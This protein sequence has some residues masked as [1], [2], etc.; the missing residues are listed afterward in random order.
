MAYSDPRTWVTGE[1]V[2][3]SLMN[4]QLRDNLDAIVEGTT[5]AY[6]NAVTGPHAIGG[7]TVDYVRLGLTGAFTSGGASTLAFG[8]YTSGVLT[9]HS[10][11]SAAIAGIK[12]NNSIVTAGN[13]TTIAQL[14]VSEPQI[15]V[16]SGSVTNSAT[17]YIESAATEATNDYALWVDA[18]ATKLD[19]TLTVVG[20]VTVNTSD[21]FIDTSENAVVIGHTAIDGQGRALEVLGTTSDSTGIELMRFSANAEGPSLAFSKSRGGAIGTEAIV[22]DDDT[23]GSIVWF[24]DD[25]T[26]QASYAASINADVDGTPGSN[27]MPGR[28]VF[29][30]TADGAVS[31]TARMTILSGGNVGIGTSD[32]S[33]KL[34]VYVDDA[35]VTGTLLLDQDST[36][37]A[38]I[39]FVLTDVISWAV[40]CDNS[41]ADTFKISQSSNLASSNRLSID[42]SG[43][44]HVPGAFSK[45]SGSFKID[46]PLP[47]K[48]DT[49]HLV[50][51]FAESPETLLIYRGTVDLVDG[52][53]EVDLD[54]AA[55]MTS[56]TWILLC[57]DEQ[58]FTSNET[59]WFHVR[60]SVAGST[61]T[62]DCE[63][64]TCTDTVSW[65]VVANRKDTHIMETA[66]TDENGYA[67]VEP[68]KP[69]PEEPEP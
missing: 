47:A 44:V 6:V 63:E 35:G 55:G 5:G 58:C 49:H 28:L 3:A 64:A 30:T 69:E 2:T 52:T 50:H 39:R 67:I 66:W 4:A 42:T 56:G 24:G 9:G 18:G 61:L 36:G 53:A 51:S 15:T 65:M 11:D 20:D 16:G 22:Q 62:I 40:G 33:N 34:H 54:T 7:S 29:S 27:D 8:V 46:H 43:A 31:P 23:I 37:D 21:L 17:V 13:C 60:G 45:G 41:D 68:L 57:R 48:T 19:G 14:W 1:L 59:G 12:A 25:G 32:P 26:D 10:G 38:S